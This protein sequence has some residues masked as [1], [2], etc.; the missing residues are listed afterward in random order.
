MPAHQLGIHLRSRRQRL[1]VRQ[2]DLAEL[3]GVGLRTLIA[4]EKGEANPSLETLTKIADVLGMELTL[5]VKA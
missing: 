2:S 3:A 4:I 1:G 5:A